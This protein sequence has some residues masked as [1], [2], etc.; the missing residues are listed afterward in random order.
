MALPS[1][2]SNVSTATKKLVRSR[3]FNWRVP[4]KPVVLAWRESFVLKL[5][6][7]WSQLAQVCLSLLLFSMIFLSLGYVHDV[8]SDCLFGLFVVVY[9]SFSFFFGVCFL[10]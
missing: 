3:V 5:A 1:K 6:I 4:I 10:M 2:S 7:K 8:F 9:L